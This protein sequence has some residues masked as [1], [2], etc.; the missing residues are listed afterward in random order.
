MNSTERF[1]FVMDICEQYDIS[2]CSRTHTLFDDLR[3][4]ELY[5]RIKIESIITIIRGIEEREE[6][7]PNKYPEYIMSKLRQRRGLEK[8]DTSKDA[9]INSM[10]ADEVF[11]EICIW[12]GLLGGYDYTIKRWINDIYGIKLGS[13]DIY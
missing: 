4:D 6:K 10:S 13:E 12:D 8:Y 1:K 2:N 3:E 9:D 11:G 5:D 7:N